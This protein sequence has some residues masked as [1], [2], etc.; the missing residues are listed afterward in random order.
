MTD[1]EPRTPADWWL[2]LRGPALLLEELDLA[3]AARCERAEEARAVLELGVA[4]YCR[5]QWLLPALTARQPQET[6]YSLRQVLAQGREHPAFDVLARTVPARMRSG[7][8]TAELFGILCDAIESETWRDTGDAGT[9]ADAGTGDGPGF[10][11]DSRIGISGC[12]PHLVEFSEAYLGISDGEEPDEVIAGYIAGFH[13]RHCGWILPGLVGEAHRAIATYP[14][15]ELMSEAFDRTLP[16]ASVSGATWAQW[17]GRLAD[18]LTRH[19]KEQ[20]AHA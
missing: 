20:H 2:R 13:P 14:T 15:E 12:F 17:F 8:G 11:P 16:L 7:T 3:A 10:R 5:R 18:E 9:G 4:Q 1:T 6:A 19:M